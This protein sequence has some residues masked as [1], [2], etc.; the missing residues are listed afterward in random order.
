MREDFR[1]KSGEPRALK[2]AARQATKKEK[3][4]LGSESD[5]RKKKRD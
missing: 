1:K 3:N 4:N 5:R 2:K